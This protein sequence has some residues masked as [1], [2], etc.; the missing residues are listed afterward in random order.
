MKPRVY[1]DMS[2]E[3]E[4]RRA[5]NREASR[6]FYRRKKLGLPPLKI[7]PKLSHLTEDERQE[8]RRKAKAEDNKRRMGLVN[9]LAK[10]GIISPSHVQHDEPLSRYLADKMIRQEAGI[11][12]RAGFNIIGDGCFRARSYPHHS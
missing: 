12:T 6:R 2:P 10:D 8:Y 3:A 7:M 4:K 9:G 5:A 11:S 1:K